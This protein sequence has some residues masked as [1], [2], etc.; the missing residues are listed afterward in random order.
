MMLV[1]KR[2]RFRYGIFIIGAVSWILCLFHF[3]SKVYAQSAPNFLIILADDLGF[4]DLGCYGGEIQTPNLDKLGQQGLRFTQFY[5]T[6]RCWPTRASL[7]TGYYPHQIGFDRVPGDP[8]IERHNRPAWAPLLP[9]MLKPLGYRSYHSGKWHL[10][11]PPLKCGF[12]RAY[13]LDDHGRYFSPQTHSL[14][15]VRLPPVKRESGY[16]ATT[17]VADQAIAFLQEHHEQHSDQP[18]FQ[19]LAFTAPHFPLHALPEDIE[20][21]SHAYAAGWETLRM[22]RWQ[23]LRQMGIV[24]GELPD[25]ESEVGPPYD[26]PQAMEVLGPDEVN[27]PVPWETLTAEQKRFQANK[28]AIHAAMV[29]RMDQEIGRVLGQLRAMQQWDNTVIFFLSDNGASAEIMVRDDGHDPTAP[30]GSAA[31]HLCLGPGFS[32]ASNS[33]FR[34]HKTWVHEGGIH[35]PLIVHWPAGIK[36]PEQLNHSLGHVIDICPTIIELAK[37]SHAAE[38]GSDDSSPPQDGTS[39]VTPPR[40][41]VSLASAIQQNNSVNR[42]WLWW[43][44]E[45]NRALRKGD[46]KLVASGGGPWELYNISQDPTENQNLALAA[47]ERVSDLANQLQQILEQ[48]RNQA[49]QQK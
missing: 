28:M 40:P 45:K 46:W 21:Y 10:D 35:T 11:G 34:R 19:F 5:N 4:S 7:L 24:S 13:S 20:K 15:G 32:S 18:F 48:I 42:E 43:S 2:V 27:R 25:L 44:H 37:Q 9:E 17:M 30:A 16:Y 36:T 8:P 38:N 33:P 1:Y 39:K 26:F 29:D 3:E 23:R 14:D 22:E 31:S 12:D 47:P 6:G 41:G 49:Q